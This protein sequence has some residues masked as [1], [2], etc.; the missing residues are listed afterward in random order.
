[1]KP[2]DLP[3]VKPLGVLGERIRQLLRDAVDECLIDATR[4]GGTTPKATRLTALMTAVNTAI[5]SVRDTTAPA[6]ST[7]TQ[8]FG[9]AEIALLYGEQLDADFVPVAADF[10]ISSPTRTVTGVRID[11]RTVYV[12]YS[13]TVLVTSDTPDIAYTQNA[14]AGH[15]DAAGNLAASFT[16]AAVTV[17]GS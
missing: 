5:A 14:T 1:M 3:R 4:K 12:A 6:I 13:G 15:R 17:A 8:A 2:S 7:R 9:V 11:N 16:A 10:V